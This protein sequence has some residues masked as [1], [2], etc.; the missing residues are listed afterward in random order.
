[1]RKKK[2]DH[3]AEMRRQQKEAQKMDDVAH[4]AR[5]VYRGIG[6]AEGDTEMQEE[7]KEESVKRS[8]DDY[9]RIV[10]KNT[11]FFSTFDAD[12]LL[13]MIKTYADEV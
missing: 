3:D 6:D 12:A 13:G 7:T 10:H 11:E 5:R 8:I 1:M 2:I 4:G 9:V